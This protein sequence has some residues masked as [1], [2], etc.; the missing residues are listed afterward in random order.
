MSSYTSHLVEGVEDLNFD[1]DSNV[2]PVN[3]T[4]DN[5]EQTPDLVP[6]T[7]NSQFMHT[8]DFR[9]L[10]V[11]FV[12]VDTLVAMRWLDR[13]W[14]AVVEKKLTELEEDEPYGKIIVHGGNDVSWSEADSDARKKKMKP[15][16]K[17]VFLL[18][19]TKVGDYA[20]K[21]A[22]IL[23]LRSVVVVDIP[24]GI[25]S[26]GD[27]SFFQC[28]YL[29]YIKFPKSLTS[30]GRSSF[31]SCFSLEQVDL[32]HT[33][34]EELG[35]DAFTSCTNLREMKFPDSL[36]KFGYGVFS[37]CKKLDLSSLT[38]NPVFTVDGNDISR[39]KAW[40]EERK[41]RMKQVTKVVFLLNITK[42]GEW[43]C[44]WASI[45]VAVDIPEGITIID[46]GSF[47]GCSSLKDIKFPKSLTSIGGAS[48]GKCFSLEKV[49]LLHTN[50]RA[51]GNYAFA[52]CTSLREMKVPDSLQTLNGQVFYDCSALVP[53][54]IDVNDVNAVIAY[55]R[56]LQ[57]LKTAK[58]K[59]ARKNTK[60]EKCVNCSKTFDV[61][62]T[63]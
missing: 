28:Y 1:V 31:R 56:S 15:V 16:K 25:T 52:Y 45:L 63:S 33:N 57:P 18:N 6:Q 51:L 42:V 49:D 10:F 48:F 3:S 55:L 44:S 41:E 40:S 36:V 39:D 47:A 60:P 53:S 14:H 43:A 37:E 34:V 30:I 4:E 32:L 46:F 13:K 7:V 54:D 62:I 61:P 12:M 21:G 29:K 59:K 8:D 22:S 5:A 58:K 38:F 27:R 24:E 19:T 20:F 9:R 17:I 23:G 50:V 35:D 26:I 2:P 11:E